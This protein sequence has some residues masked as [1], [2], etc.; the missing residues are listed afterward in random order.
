VTFFP[1]DPSGIRRNTTYMAGMTD[2]S[3]RTRLLYNSANM[4]CDGEIGRYAKYAAQNRLPIWFDD[5]YETDLDEWGV[6]WEQAQNVMHIKHNNEIHSGFAAYILLWGLLPK[7]QLRARVMSLP[8]MR[9]IGHVLY[10]KVFSGVCYR[11]SRSERKMAEA[12]RAMNPQQ[13]GTD[14]SAR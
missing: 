12:R 6:T 3:P 5:L 14:T 4:M 7:Y 2:T 10:Q 9:K 11:C 13:T 1:L 8:I